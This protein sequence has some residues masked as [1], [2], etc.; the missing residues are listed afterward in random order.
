MKANLNNY[1]FHYY[2]RS[3]TP[4]TVGDRQRETKRV[5]IHSIQLPAKTGSS[6]LRE[7]LPDPHGLHGKSKGAGLHYLR[8]HRTEA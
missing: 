6:R 2:S 7:S 4:G 1:F 3:I 8:V 5:T